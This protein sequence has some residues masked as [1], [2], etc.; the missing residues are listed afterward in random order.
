MLV[1]QVEPSKLNS[2]HRKDEADHQIGAWIGRQAGR[3]IALTVALGLLSACSAA[4]LSGS[5]KASS[6]QNPSNGFSE[7]GLAGVPSSAGVASLPENSNGLHRPD[8]DRT[9]QLIGLTGPEIGDLFGRPLLQRVERP[10]SVW[11]YRGTDC[12]LFVFFYDG[13]DMAR[14]SYVEARSR[15][16]ARLVGDMDCVRSVRERHMQK[17]L[18]G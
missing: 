9:V 11:T 2:S 10:A 8:S 6:A 17:D 4:S 18:A 5:T 3:A 16:D 1:R 14:V 12:V 15:R 13:N 7:A